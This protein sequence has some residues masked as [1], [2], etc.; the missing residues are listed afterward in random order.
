ML[1]VTTRSD[2]ETMYNFRRRKYGV[3][4]KLKTLC[5]LKK[6]VISRKSKTKMVFMFL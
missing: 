6:I 4:A 5:K 3:S 2:W 1:A